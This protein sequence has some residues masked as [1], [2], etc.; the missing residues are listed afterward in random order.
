MYIGRGWKRV[1]LESSKNFNTCWSLSVRS[2]E[3]RVSK[4]SS[5]VDNVNIRLE[6]VLKSLAFSTVAKKMVRR[7]ARKVEKA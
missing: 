6:V 2:A 5:I 7:A 3:F 4:V 1:D